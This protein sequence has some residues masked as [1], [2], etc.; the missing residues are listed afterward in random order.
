MI[1]RLTASLLAFCI[2]L[3]MCWCCAAVAEAA[4]DTGCCAM[5]QHESC[6]DTSQQGGQ[7]PHCPCLKHEDSRDTADTG[8]S[9]PASELKLLNAGIWQ[10]EDLPFAA[11]NFLARNTAASHDGRPPGTAPPIYQRHCA[12]LM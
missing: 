12:L 6:G 4:P 1:A 3:P 7:E 11:K 10:T 5:M 8:V 2:A 9:M